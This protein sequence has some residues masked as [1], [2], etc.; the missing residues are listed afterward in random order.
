VVFPGFK[1]GVK[2][3]MKILMCTNGKKH[4][5][6]AIRFAGELFGAS[7]PD[8]I[9]LYVK[10]PPRKAKKDFLDKG[11]EILSKF[12]IKARTKLVTNKSIVQGILE[13]KR[14]GNYEML[15]LGSRGVSDIL[16]GISSKILGDVP[17]NILQHIS[18]STLIVKEPAHI[19]KVLICTDG[20]AAAEKAVK[21]W[22]KLDKTNRQEDVNWRSPSVHLINVIPEFYTRFKDFLG[23][24]S[25]EHLDILGSLPGKRT[26]VLYKDK[27]ILEKYGVKVKV[28]LREGH[29]DQEILEEG[30][31]HDLIVMG[32]KG[33]RRDTFGHHLIPI[34]Q[35]S[36]IPVLVIKSKS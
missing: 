36:K 8:V 27:K 1:K 29:V 26:E 34:V 18:I 7:K 28:K 33:Q 30:D 13:E 15:V 2:K 21:F 23:P 11:A 12:G 25:K 5:E 24:V 20:S 16:P 17:S 22:G 6:N 9:L 32:R 10:V 14:K 19:D 31:G 4:A 35:Q 3:K